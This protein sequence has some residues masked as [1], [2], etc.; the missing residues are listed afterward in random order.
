[1]IEEYLERREKEIRILF[2]KMMSKSSVLIENWKEQC[3]NCIQ[4]E[5]VESIDK[6][7][8]DLVDLL[9]NCG[10]EKM[11]KIKNK[12]NS[13]IRMAGNEKQLCNETGVRQAK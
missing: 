7:R 4:M 3:W 10:Y 8:D 1:M 13:H 5:D 12:V 9:E 6:I 2:E 11:M